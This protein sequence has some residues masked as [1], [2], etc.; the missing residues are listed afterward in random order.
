MI[1]QDGVSQLVYIDLAELG[2]HRKISFG[3]NVVAAPFSGV[4]INSLTVTELE[5]KLN[6]N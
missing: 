3:E 1:E 2:D 5:K 6:Q 4:Q